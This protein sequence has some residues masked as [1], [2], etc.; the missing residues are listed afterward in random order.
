MSCPRLTSLSIRA[1]TRSVIG[2]SN[3][4]HRGILRVVSFK[5]MRGLRRHWRPWALT[6]ASTAVL[7]SA[8]YTIAVTGI[9]VKPL[10]ATAATEL[11]Y[12]VE[13]GDEAV[14]Q[15]LTGQITKAGYAPVPAA[16]ADQ[17]DVAL[18]RAQTPGATPVLEAASGAPAQLNTTGPTS[19]KIV[20][21]AAKP[22][23]YLGTH[24]R[25]GLPA[26]KLAALTTNLTAN[27]KT[28]PANTWSLTALGDIIIGRTTYL[29]IQRYGDPNKP[30]AYFADTIR[31]SDLALADLEC[32]ISDAHTIVTDGG[33]TFASPA[34]SAA[35]LKAAGIDAVNVANNHSFNVGAAGFT[36]TLDAM[37][38]LGI[39]TFGG[40]RNDQEAHSPTILTV[41]GVKVALLGYS[42]IVGSTPAGANTPGMAHLSMAPWDPF[43]EAEAARMESDIKAAKAQADLV[44][45]Y[46]HWGTEYT[47]DANADQRQ[48]A[49]RA[50]DAGADLI[51]GTHPH[52]VQGVEWYKD[53]LIT[54][55][56]GNFI[57]DQEWSTKTKQGT[58]LKATFNG[59][60]LTSAELVPYQIEDYLQP[61]PVGE[62]T[63]AGILGDVFAHSWWPAP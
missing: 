48:I 28:A 30:F 54:Y 63:A 3:Y 13:G 56:L 40:G 45:V 41:K 16:A 39:P 6:A 10:P 26:A 33:M 20:T 25:A 14:T 1:P 23:Y 11:R 57:F 17:A 60:H 18:T 47:H 24:P 43:N 21:A 42:S 31:D 22:S 62:A 4:T 7:A 58:F 59:A 19:A 55:S 12:W 50:I 49:H 37:A 44:M 52:W 53:K 35:G 51:L 8:A 2:H 36:D 32:T 27:L 9:W 29:Q 5:V 34:S 38:H 15:Q 46:Y 61:R